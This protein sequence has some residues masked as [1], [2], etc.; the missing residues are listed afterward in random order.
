MPDPETHAA[1]WAPRP[2]TPVRARK[3]STVPSRGI[4]RAVSQENVEVVRRVY[5]AAAGRDRATVLALY[6]PDVELDLSRIPLAALTG[7][8]IYRGHDGLRSMFRDWY[9]AFE[10]YE[11]HCEELI[12]AGEQVIS[13]LTGRGRGRASGTDVEMP[14]FIVWTIRDGKVVRLVWFPTRTDALEAAGREE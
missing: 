12:E 5:D 10:N 1:G 2:L 4:L 11:E 7:Q 9:E 14:F 13:V 3:R 8:G 6:D